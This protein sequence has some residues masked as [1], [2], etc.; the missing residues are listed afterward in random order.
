MKLSASENSDGE[1]SLEGVDALNQMG[2]AV[3][4]TVD[5]KTREVNGATPLKVALTKN[6]KEAKV[7][8][9]HSAKEIASGMS[10]FKAIQAVGGLQ[11][12]F[13]AP[14]SL[15]GAVA[16]YAVVD[17][18]GKVVASGAIKAAAGSNSLNIATPKRGV[19]FVQLKLG[20]QNASAK[21]LVK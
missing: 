21:V 15:A 8:V 11:V 16:S 6:S 1:L 9:V 14:Q 2:F 18:K 4:V 17:V 5:G 12:D 10:G 13:D 3:Y 20:S 19:Y 7:R